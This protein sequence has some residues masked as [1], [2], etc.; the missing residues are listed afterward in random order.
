MIRAGGRAAQ[1]YNKHFDKGSFNVIF[2][3]IAGMMGS[4]FRDFFLIMW[5]SLATL[6]LIVCFVLE[7]VACF[8]FVEGPKG[9]CNSLNHNQKALYSRA[10]GDNPKN[11]GLHPWFITGYTDGDGSFSIKVYKREGSKF[12]FNL[13]FPR[14]G[15]HPHGVN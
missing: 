5:I 14:G 10:K 13:S 3:N 15:V 1:I 4:Y 8:L 6:G 9:G 11:Y 7:N 2:S 12:G